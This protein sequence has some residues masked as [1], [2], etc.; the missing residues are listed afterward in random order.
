MGLFEN[1]DDKT[2]IAD[3]TEFAETGKL[4]LRQ[5]ELDVS[6]DRVSTGEVNLRK[7][8]V[9]EQKTINVP[10]THEEVVIERKAINNEPSDAPI[11]AEE[12]IRIPVSEEKVEVGKHT[13]IIGEISAHKREVEETEQIAETLKRE[14]ARVET[15]GDPNIV[16]DE[17]INDLQ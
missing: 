2:E 15:T 7:E 4:R 13:V 5:E 3:E 1:K 10:V 11:G 14:E 6:K 17:T 9:E 8:V 12:T 16:S